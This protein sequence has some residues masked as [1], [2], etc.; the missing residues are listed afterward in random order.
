MAILQTGAV[1]LVALMRHCC[2]CCLTIFL[3]NRHTRFL[4]T[5]TD[6][7]ECALTRH[8]TESLFYSKL[9]SSW[10]YLH[11]IILCH[12]HTVTR[13]RR[14]WER[15]VCMYDDCSHESLARTHTC[16]LCSRLIM[17]SKFPLATLS[18]RHLDAYHNH[19][20]PTHLPE[21]PYIRK[22]RRNLAKTLKNESLYSL[23]RTHTFI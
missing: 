13:S 7:I 10:I 15:D 6:Y 11:K 2:C 21:T 3:H 19:K 22:S 14:E 20:V 23:F 9:L 8:G 16:K 12:T 5:S 17:P 1:S 4:R 18:H